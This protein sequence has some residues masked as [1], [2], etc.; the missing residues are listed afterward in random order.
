[1]G[2]E[3]ELSYNCCY[4]HTKDEI[5]VHA[6]KKMSIIWLSRYYVGA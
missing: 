4:Y 6:T 2:E 5:I 3:V 1:M